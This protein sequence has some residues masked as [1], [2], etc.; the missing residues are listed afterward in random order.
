V[1][2]VRGAAPCLAPCAARRTTQGRGAQGQ[3]EAQGQAQC[4]G[5]RHFPLASTGLQT[6]MEL[7]KKLG[8]SARQVQVCFQNKRQRERKISRSK[9]MLSTP[10]LPDTPAVVAVDASARDVRDVAHHPNHEYIMIAHREGLPRGYTAG[11]YSYRM[12]RR[13]CMHRR[14]R[15]SF[16]NQPPKTIR[17]L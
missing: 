12:H 16:P 9:G 6:R 10:G 13:F 14:F 4:H 3:A 5:R 1:G 2:T 7:S 15:Y 11:L 8:V 17:L